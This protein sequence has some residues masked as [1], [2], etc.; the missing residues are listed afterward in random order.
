MAKKVLRVVDA[1]EGNV[2][3]YREDSTE[4][5]DTCGNAIALAYELALHSFMG[6]EIVYEGMV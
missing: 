4:A 1:G 3:I 6:Y 2:S 5:Y